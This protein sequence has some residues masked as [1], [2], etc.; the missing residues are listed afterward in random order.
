MPRPHGFA[1]EAYESGT[2]R[3]THHGHPAATLNGPRAAR[4]LDEVAAGDPQLVM[5]RRTGNHRR[6]NERTARDHP[7]NRP[8]GRR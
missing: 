4:F 6:G 1:Y 7:R 8:R 2:V 5:A 3:I